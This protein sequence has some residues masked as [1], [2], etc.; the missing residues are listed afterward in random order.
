[1]KEKRTASL[2]F[3]LTELLI[4]VAI[5]GVLA[6]I[7]IPMYKR[8][9][10]K[11]YR[12][13]GVSTLGYFNRLTTSYIEEHPGYP[14]FEGYLVD[15]SDT[16][17]NKDDPNAGPSSANPLPGIGFGVESC[18]NRPWAYYIKPR[19]PGG[20][21]IVYAVNRDKYIFGCPRSSEQMTMSNCRRLCQKKEL[22]D[23]SNCVS[24]P[25]SYCGYTDEYSCN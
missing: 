9:R 22:V 10:L 15:E 18:Q 14:L 2:G 4:V 12:A 8:S 25:D 19:N 11:A 5:I 23:F 6:T 7:G 1:M 20:E 21:Y 3:S 13:G 24:A 16:N 17:C